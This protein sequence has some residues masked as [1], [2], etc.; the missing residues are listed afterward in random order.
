MVAVLVFVGNEAILYSL[1]FFYS[2]ISHL[3]NF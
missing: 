3:H 1:L 2:D